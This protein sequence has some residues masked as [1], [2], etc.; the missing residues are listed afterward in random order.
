[1]S[2]K[3]AI[4]ELF[5]LNLTVSTLIILITFLTIWVIK[6]KSTVKGFLKIWKKWKEDTEVSGMSI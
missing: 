3:I 2:L 5:D 1:M 4:H 6:V